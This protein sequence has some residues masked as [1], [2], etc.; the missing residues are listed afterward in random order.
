MAE[1]AGVFR[2]RPA[3]GLEDGEGAPLV[4]ERARRH[5]PGLEEELTQ[6]LVQ[7]GGLEGRVGRSR[8][9]RHEILH[10]RERTKEPVEP[11]T[12]LANLVLEA[13]QP[14]RG[15]HQVEDEPAIS[16]MAGCQ[17]LAE[18]HLLSEAL[19]RA[20]RIPRFA[21]NGLPWTSATFW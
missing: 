8:L 3:R 11:G 17:R 5:L 4:L 19:D 9:A 16:R 13:R 21:A 15:P 12:R 1:E 20:G 18:R 10:R 2:M 7:L 14:A 6:V